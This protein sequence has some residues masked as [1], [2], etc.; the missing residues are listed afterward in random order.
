M[1]ARID[2][3][4]PYLLLLAC[5][6]TEKHSTGRK[7]GFERRYCMELCVPQSLLILMAIFC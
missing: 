5:S 6:E 4:H 7:S 3:I 1:S 2:W